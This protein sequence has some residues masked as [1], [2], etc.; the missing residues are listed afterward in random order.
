MSRIILL[1]YGEIFLKSPPVKRIYK[2]RLKN[3]IKHG[4][5]G[6]GIASTITMPRGRLFLK[7]G[8]CDLDAVCGLLKRTFGIVSFSICHHLDTSDIETIQEFVK[9]NYDE[10]VDER[11]KFAVRGKR[12]GSHPYTSVELGKLVGDVVDRDVDLDDPDVEI[13]VEVRNDNTYIYTEIIDGPGGLPVGS[14]GK[15]VCLLSGGIDS[16]VAA[17][18]MMKRGCQIIALYADTVPYGGDMGIDRVEAVL[19]TLQEWSMG[20]QIP[21]YSFDHGQILKTILDNIEIPENLT[22]LL[23]KRMMYRAANSIADKK[24]AMGVVTGETLGEVASQT[25]NNIAVLD[26]ASEMPVFRPLI[27]NDK[28]ENIE[29]AKRIGTYDQS[30][31]ISSECGAV[32]SEPRTMGN[33]E[34]ITEAESHIDVHGI[35]ENIMDSMKRVDY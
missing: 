26:N 10:W 14:A 27:G 16:P 18:K 21:L 12:A 7:V 2:K 34:E 3:N 8:E 5:S 31:S 19:K 1:R 25:L 22:C 24:G 9:S 11:E 15:V 23:C 33:L 32:P 29:M 20:W 28:R 4:L 35:L 13:F 17:W 6:L 30:I